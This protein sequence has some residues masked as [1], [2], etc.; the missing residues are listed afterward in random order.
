[1]FYIIVSIVIIQRLTELVIAKRNEKWLR[2]NGAVE[3]GNEHYKYIVL[4]HIMFFIS[5][6]IEYNFKE[7][8]LEFS[9]INYLFL[10]I[11]ILMQVMRFWVLISLGKYW[12][13]KIL[14]IPG[15]QLV[16]KGP[17]RFFKHPNYIIVCC[18]IIAIPMIFDLYITAVVF[19]FLNAFVLAVRIKEEN[20]V[21][22]AR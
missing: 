6:F 4:Q 1:M 21:L 18:E 17:Y 20:K 10:L 19:T 15:S 16:S 11:F 7:R 2:A 8:H 13:T 14:R 9:V 5:M 3:Y 22:S 12:N